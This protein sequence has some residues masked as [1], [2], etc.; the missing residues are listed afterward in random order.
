MQAP[1]GLKVVFTD[2]NE[3]YD[4]CYIIYTGTVV[5]NT[6]EDT[7]EEEEDHHERAAG[8]YTI[9]FDP[10]DND[11]AV[12]E[13]EEWELQEIVNGNNLFNKL[14]TLFTNPNT[15]YLKERVAVDGDLQSVHFGVIVERLENDMWRVEYDEEHNGIE[16]TTLNSAMVKEG[17]CFFRALK[18][19]YD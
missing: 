18:R 17:I 10:N 9:E 13:P 14:D 3:Y 16:N 19:N 12:I 4:D 6:D 2:K 7:D 5:E 1:I 8:K 15:K 11:D